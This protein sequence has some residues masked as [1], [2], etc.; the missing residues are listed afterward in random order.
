[1]KWQQDGRKVFIKYKKATIYWTVPSD[2]Q[3]KGVHPDALRL[4][5]KLLFLPFHK[6]SVMSVEPKNDRVPKT[7]VGLSYSGGVDSTASMLLLPEDTVVSYMWRDFKSQLTHANLIKLVKAEKE[8]KIWTIRSNH[9]KVRTFNRL[10]TGF[11]TDLAC[12]TH[13]ILMSDYHNIGRIAAGT[14]LGSAYLYQGV[15]QDFGNDRWYWKFYGKM[16][17]DHGFDLVFPVAGLSEVL[18]TK[19]VA[20]SKYRGL[21]QACVRQT[22]GCGACYK[23][24]RKRLLLAKPG[25]GKSVRMPNE[26]RNYLNHTPP[27]HPTSSLYALQKHGIKPN[28][29]RVYLEGHDYSYLDYYHPTFIQD[30]IPEDLRQGIEDKLRK[31]KCEPMN[32]ENFQKMKS[33]NLKKI[34]KAK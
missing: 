24:Y 5:E 30:I 27:K 13:L 4:I 9:E 1:M 28:V 16:F 34:K 15:Y 22:N 19:V 11:S 33:C 26:A 20:Q 21:A 10:P 3:L 17:R 32:E 25:D 14:V 6:D 23:C 2:F 18:T 7:G 12:A 31:F 8:R 29:C